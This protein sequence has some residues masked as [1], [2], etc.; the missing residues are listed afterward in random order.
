MAYINE[1]EQDTNSRQRTGRIVAILCVLWW[2][3]SIG[4]VIFVINSSS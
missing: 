4:G 1:T 2:I 3:A